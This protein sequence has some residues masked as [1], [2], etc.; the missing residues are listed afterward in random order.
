[1]G[2]VTAVLDAVP[3]GSCEPALWSTTKHRKRETLSLQNSL[4]HFGLVQPLAVRELPSPEGVERLETI[5][6]SKRLVLFKEQMAGQNP[7]V[8]VVNYGPIDDATA[9]RLHLALNMTRGKAG[10]GELADALE[11]VV[12]SGLTIEDQAQTEVHLLS[13]LPIPS[14]GID[15][16]IEKLRKKAGPKPLDVDPE[17][18]EGWISFRFKVHPDA[19]EVCDRALTL[20]EQSTKCQRSIAFER[21]C[22]DHLAGPI[23]ARQ[24]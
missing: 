12:Q 8:Q 1:M 21:I 16:T 14:R 3:L 19:A 10:P 18:G 24:P 7:T 15:K 22:A 5:D 2:S 20:V 6:G 4:A 9:R 23:I 17:T 11:S 13:I